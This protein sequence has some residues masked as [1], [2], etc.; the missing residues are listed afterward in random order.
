MSKEKDGKK[1]P[2]KTAPL[3]TQKEKKA[4]KALKKQGKTPTED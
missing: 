3:K 2:D 1:K 4:L